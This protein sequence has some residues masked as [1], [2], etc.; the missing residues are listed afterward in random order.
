MYCASDITEDNIKLSCKGIQKDC[1]NF[2]CHDV[3]L[4]KHE[5]KLLNKHSVVLMAI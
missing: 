5:N 3:L 4:N 2:N 1:N